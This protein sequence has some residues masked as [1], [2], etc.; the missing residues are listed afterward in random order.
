MMNDDADHWDTVADPLQN[1]QTEA[2]SSDD[3]AKE[4]DLSGGQTFLKMMFDKQTPEEIKRGIV[5]Q[6]LLASIRSC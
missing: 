1:P 2:D 5:S 3:R 6:A 4:M